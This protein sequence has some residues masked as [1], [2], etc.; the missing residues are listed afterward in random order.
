MSA[1]LNLTD[2][3][4]PA[5]TAQGVTANPATARGHAII[6]HAATE[7]PGRSVGG[8]EDPHAGAADTFDHTKFRFVHKP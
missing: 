4:G 6:S 1:I 5:S 3:A 2:C 8:L 7:Q